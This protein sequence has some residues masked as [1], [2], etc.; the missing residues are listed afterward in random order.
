MNIKAF[1]ALLLSFCILLPAFAQTRPAELPPAPP[2]Q[3]KPADDKDDDVVKITT[4]LV[5]VDAVVTKDGKPVT[6]L[7]ADDFE[8]YQDGRQ[9][10]IT[11]FAYISNV[12]AA[13]TAVAPPVPRDKKALVPPVTP[14]RVNEPHRTVA[15]V[16]DDLGMSAESM[17]LARN[18]LKKFLAEKL[19]PNDLVAIIRTGGE[20]GVLQQFTNDRRLLD[21]ARERLRWNHC[22]RVGINVFTPVGSGISGGMGLEGFPCGGNSITK[23]L[24][25][26][27]F[28]L[29]GMAELPGRK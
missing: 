4:N 18:Q 12:P 21:R 23:S 3:Q 29:D 19:Q 11:S 20:L 17:G 10:T 5:Q 24:R 28:I 1:L 13:S 16:V 15:L 8:I 22:S 27:R 14:V 25:A 7:T 26:L 6:N 2:Q 9:Q